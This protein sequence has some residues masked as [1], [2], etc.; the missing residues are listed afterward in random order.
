[1]DEIEPIRAEYRRQNPR[2]QRIG[3]NK[4]ADGG[5]HEFPRGWRDGAYQEPCA[6]LN[7]CFNDHTGPGGVH[8]QPAEHPFERQ[9]AWKMHADPK[10][11]DLRRALE[12]DGKP[13]AKVELYQQDVDEWLARDLG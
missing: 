13:N 7:L 1:M 9:A 11:Y 4:I 6:W 3:C 10:N 2:C 5:I 12:L 8:D